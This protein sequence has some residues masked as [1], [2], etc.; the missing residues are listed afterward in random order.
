[1]G[2]ELLARNRVL[3]WNDATNFAPLPGA[4]RPS[5]SRA[6]PPFSRALPSVRPFFLKTTV[7]VGVSAG[8][9]SAVTVATRIYFVRPLAS[10]WVVMLRVVTVGDCADRLLEDRAHGPEVVDR[11]AVDRLNSG[12]AHGQATKSSTWPCPCS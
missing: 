6:T 8:S 5:T 1:M 9:P 2:G 11:A 7:P 12:F 10:V 4:F 3:F